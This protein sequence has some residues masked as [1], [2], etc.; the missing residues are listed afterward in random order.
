MIRLAVC[1]MI[2]SGWTSWCLGQ[3]IKR[4]TYF[5]VE[6][7]TLK[8]EYFVYDTLLNH[9]DGPYTSYYLSGNIKSMGQY[10]F[11]KATGEWEYFYE[12][13]NLKSAGSF[14]RGKTVG[15]WTYYYENGSK[16][17]EG[18]LD[19]NV[20]AGHWIYFYENGEI[21]NQGEYDAGVKIGSWLYYYE[22][23]SL[24]AKATYQN[25]S[26][27][28]KE[29]YMSGDLKMVG[30]NHL[31]KSDSLWTYFYQS[32]EKMAEG[33]YHDGVK[34]GTWKYYFKNGI[35]SAEGGFDKGN[36][37]G[38]W[39]YYYPSGAK[40]SEGLKKNGMKDGYWKMF[41]ET[42]ET[43]GV[44]ELNEGTGEYKEYYTSGKLKVSG[45][46]KGDLNDGHWIYYDE[47]G[48]IEG[49]ADFIDGVGNY[50]G[51]YLD[52]SIKMKG[53]ISNGRRVGEWILYDHDGSIAGK[54]H[55]V[56][57][58]EN[59]IWEYDQTISEI[60]ANYEKPEY[61]F[62]NNKNRAFE[63]VVNEYKG[64][65]IGGNPAFSL[66]GFLPL[67]LE[68]YLQERLGYEL[69]YIHHR[70]PFYISHRGINTGDLYLNGGQLQVKQKFYMQDEQYGMLYWGQLIGAK[71]MRY[72]ALPSLD[73]STSTIEA[74]EWDYY[75]GLI[76]GDRW[77]QNAGN[78][79]LTIDIYFGIGLGYR[80]YQRN[81]SDRRFDPYFS[82]IHQSKA[83]VPVLFGLNIGY[84]GF[85]KYRT[86]PIPS[87][88]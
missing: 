62:K 49:M 53:K 42:G 87:R 77:T 6:K 13:G 54:Y 3:N 66:F 88:R 1:V 33:Y 9:L 20:K 47:E 40:S 83:Y 69:E 80:D 63:E 23:G 48:H 32:G 85:K 12:N 27:V 58:E 8:E 16:R 60:D 35:V 28:Y 7:T 17:S 43:K 26:G 71:H 14:F 73:L 46:F 76:I 30:R 75:C 37:I 21:K 15:I 11:N 29:Y 57:H 59:E 70:R 55:P 81:Y 82:D 67:S 51:F 4:A 18:I 86:S 34:T 10:G 5:D 44:G 19:D 2:V 74:S 45:R 22:N 64:V 84:L 72:S 38:N 36:T 68:F 31:G 50:E 56:Y 52:G 65:I 39:I 24:K 25:G 41:Y 79:G 61:R 78:A